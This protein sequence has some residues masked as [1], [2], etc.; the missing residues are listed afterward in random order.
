VRDVRQLD[1][2]DEERAAGEKF[3]VFIPGDPLAEYT[4]PHVR[5]LPFSIRVL[6]PWAETP[7]RVQNTERTEEQESDNRSMEIATTE[8]TRLLITCVLEKEKPLTRAAMG[9]KPEA[10]KRTRRTGKNLIAFRKMLKAERKKGARVEELAEQHGVST[11]YIY[12]LGA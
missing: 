12:R 6:T 5:T 1:I 9:V 3:L 2:V 10:G 7:C 4:V 11:A 8:Q